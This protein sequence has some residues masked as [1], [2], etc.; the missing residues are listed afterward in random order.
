MTGIITVEDHGDEY[1]ITDIIAVQ[2]QPRDLELTRELN[3]NNRQDHGM[4]N[5][6]KLLNNWLKEAV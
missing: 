5:I 1:H 2:Q 3:N 6:E 4:I